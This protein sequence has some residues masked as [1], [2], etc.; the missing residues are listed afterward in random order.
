MIKIG[1]KA[2]SFLSVYTEVK[3]EIRVGMGRMLIELY[4]MLPEETGRFLKDCN[5]NTYF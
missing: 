3:Q 2:F 4:F 5:I 1:H